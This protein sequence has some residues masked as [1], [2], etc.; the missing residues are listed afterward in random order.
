MK[1]LFFSLQHVIIYKSNHM[2]DLMQASQKSKRK[3]SMIWTEVTWFCFG[4]FCNAT[5]K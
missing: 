3:T 2:F 1:V 4:S 5:Y